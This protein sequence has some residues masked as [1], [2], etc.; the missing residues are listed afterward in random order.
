VSAPPLGER[1]FVGVE[2]QHAIT[3]F[4][5]LEAEL[6]D[7]SKFAE[8]LELATE[9]IRYLMPVRVTTAAFAPS[10]VLGEMAHFDEDRYSLGKRVQRL[11]GEY[12]WTENPPSRTRRFVSNI[13]AATTAVDGE[14]AVRSYL[15]L[16]RSRLDA[17][18][19]EWVSCE[20]HDVLRRHGD[21]FRIA[22]REITVDEAVL[23][24]Q[25][26]AVFL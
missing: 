22:R 15:L 2:D 10:Q 20:R 16:F 17:R 14:Y 1:V 12:A 6:L 18:P 5:Y 3:Y 13:R 23:R 4:L 11:L 8:W 21:S 25:N 7:E 26:L 9:D 19:A 24:T